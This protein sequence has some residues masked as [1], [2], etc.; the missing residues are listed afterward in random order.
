MMDEGQDAGAPAQEAS[1]AATQAEDRG[2]AIVCP[3]IQK[4]PL[5]IFETPVEPLGYR[6]MVVRRRKTRTDLTTEQLLNAL[7]D[8]C[9]FLM[10]EVALRSICQ[11]TNAQERMHLMGSAM[12]FATTGATVADAIGRLR[13]GGVPPA[14]EFHQRVTVERVEKT[15]QGGGG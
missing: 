10:Q 5:D 1:K 3:P 7:I 8:E 13:G 14:A 4:D 6:D 2:D 15:P 9:H 12:S 11:A